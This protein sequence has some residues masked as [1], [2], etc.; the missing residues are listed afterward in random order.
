MGS[1]LLTSGTLSPLDSFA[2]ELALPFPVRLENP[3]V[4]D[5]SQVR[6]ALCLLCMLRCAVH[7]ALCLLCIAAPPRWPCVSL[8]GEAEHKGLAAGA[9]GQAGRLR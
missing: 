7:A 6:P 1:I 5:P 4:I 2:A 3:H 8:R 9:W